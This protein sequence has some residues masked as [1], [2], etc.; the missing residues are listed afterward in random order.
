MLKWFPKYMAWWEGVIPLI[1]CFFFIVIFKFTVEKIQTSDTEYHGALIVEARY[2]EYYETYVHRT[3]Y[4]TVSCGKNCTRSVPYDCSY[5]DK[6]PEHWTVVNSLGE[7]FGIS[8]E[9]YNF[10]M[11]KWRAQPQFVELNRRINH[12]GWGCGQDGNMYKI[13]WNNDPLTSEATTTDHSY[14]NRVQAAHT[15]FDFPDVTDSDKKTYGLYDYPNLKGISQESVLGLDS[16]KWITSKEIELMKQWS[17]FLNGYLGPR[18][19]ARIYFLFFV[20]KPSLAANIQEAYWDGGNDNELVVCIG[21]SQKTREF[22][23]VRPFSWSPERKIIPEVREQIMAQKVFNAE[24][25]A[26]GVWV[27]T[28]KY[29][30]RKNFKE[31]SYV[32]VEPPTWAIWVTFF[33]TIGISFGVCWWAI[34]NQI[35]SEYDPLKTL[36]TG[37]RK[38]KY[39]NW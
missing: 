6:N 39:G 12:G 3:C 35:D 36:F 34:N 31:F 1:A 4:R 25:I 26:H 19:H 20:D 11:K 14:E 21:L 8:R 5:C 27:K 2:Y 17:K 22:Q 38:R 18:K 10:L 7:E 29:Y 15:A 16:V 33:V 13:I 30:Q 23:W 24:N 32:T 37:K 9:Y 28:E